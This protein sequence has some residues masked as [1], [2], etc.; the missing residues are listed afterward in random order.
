[1]NRSTGFHVHVGWGGNAKQLAILTGLVA[2]HETAL[3]ASTG[4]PSRELGNYSRPIKN[5][6]GHKYVCLLYTSP[7]PRD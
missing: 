5:S 4:T 2:Y 1:M 3:Y 6:D 7:S